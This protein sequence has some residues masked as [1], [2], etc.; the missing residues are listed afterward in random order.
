MASPPYHSAVPQ[1]VE[2]DKNLITQMRDFTEDVLVL[3]QDWEE[4]I[5]EVR[6][7]APHDYKDIDL[8]S[9]FSVGGISLHWTSLT[10]SEY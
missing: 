6:A 8:S 3:K 2:I 4:A 5:A 1:E 10:D 7:S 9:S